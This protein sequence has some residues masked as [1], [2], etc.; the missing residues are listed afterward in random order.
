MRP[1]YST[2]R[3]DQVH[4]SATAYLQEHVP[5]P[6]YGRKVKRSTLWAVLCVVA[7]RMTS[8]HDVCRQLRGVPSDE[9]IRKAVYAGLPDFAK[10]QKDLNNALAGRL[11]K[12]L[13]RRGQRVAIDLTLIPYHG[14]PFRSEAE[15]Y[16]GQPKRGTSHFHAYA[17]AYV[18]LRGQRYT[19]ALTTVAKGEAMK[20]VVQRLLRQVRSVGVKVSLVLLDAGFYSVQVIRYLQSARYPFLMPAE[21]R[22]RRPEHPRGP[23]GT[24]VFKAKKRSGWFQ[25]TVHN[26]FRQGA[27][28]SICVVCFNYRGKRKRHG[29]GT[30][31]YA[32]WGISGRSCAWVR[33]TYRTRFG[34]ESSYRQMNQ[35]RGRTSTRRPELRLLYVGISLILRNEWVWLHFEILSTPRRGGRVIW[36]ER[37]RLR[38]LLHWL[39]QAIEQKFGAIDSTSTERQVQSGFLQ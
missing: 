19:V 38:T 35:A 26:S 37:L 14:K 8:I 13:L 10:L 21:I 5:L 32:C 24:W 30:W 23:S 9:T 33:D 25:H 36:L 6:D 22:G 2:V 39:L 28:V 34:I 29:R 3:K 15:V 12:A 11:P 4:Q 20:D 1:N 27:R 31:V 7:A 16:R 17:T 18:V